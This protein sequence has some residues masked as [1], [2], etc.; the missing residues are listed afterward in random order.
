M[1][2]KS[3]LLYDIDSQNPFKRISDG[4]LAHIG[5]ADEFVSLFRRLNGTDFE[6]CRKIT[7]LDVE[8]EV[9]SSMFVKYGSPFKE[10]FNFG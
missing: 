8:G 1:L 7:A 6:F 5:L 10:A 4:S 3:G 2:E 9:Y